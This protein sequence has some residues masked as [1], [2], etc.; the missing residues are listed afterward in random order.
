MTATV[1]GLGT[2]QFVGGQ[3]RGQ[4]RC[5]RRSP[6]PSPATASSSPVPVSCRP[7][8][9]A[10][11]RPRA[12]ELGVDLHR[13]RRGC[14]GPGR[15]AAPWLCPARAGRYGSAAAPMAD[16]AGQEAPAGA[17]SRQA[18]TSSTCSR[19]DRDS[20]SVM[21]GIIAAAVTWA[22]AARDPVARAQWQ[23]N[24]SASSGRSPRLTLVQPLWAGVRSGS[25]H[26]LDFASG[27]TP[28]RPAL[29]GVAQL[30]SALRSGRRGRRVQISATPTQVTGHLR[31]SRVAVFVR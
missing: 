21:P 19:S 24:C 17:R 29:R 27:R 22:S 31:S 6:W 14:P 25:R 16:G 13:C 10:Q 1:P 28:W 12:R 5:A 15:A 30:G 3:G 26:P 18:R 8:T 23:Q 2:G 4:D 20:S 9:P 11:G 7:T